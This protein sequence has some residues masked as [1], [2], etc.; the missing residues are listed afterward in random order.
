MVLD[1]STVTRP[2]ETEVKVL[3]SVDRGKVTSKDSALAARMEYAR[4]PRGDGKWGLL[5]WD[6]V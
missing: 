4:S 2:R 6:H 5:D 3:L 1:E